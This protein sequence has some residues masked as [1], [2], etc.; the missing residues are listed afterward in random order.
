M[1]MMY[2]ESDVKIVGGK[3]KLLCKKRSYLLFSDYVAWLTI[4]KMSIPVRMRVYPV[5]YGK[6]MNLM[7]DD[8]RLE[9]KYIKTKK[10]MDEYFLVCR[11]FD[12]N[13]L[14][15]NRIARLCLEIRYGWVEIFLLIITFVLLTKG[16]I[17]EH[18]ILYSMGAIFIAGLVM[19][20]EVLKRYR[21]RNLILDDKYMEM[22]K[23]TR[24]PVKIDKKGG[25]AVYA[26]PLFGFKTVR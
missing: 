17:G 16:L 4:Q 12:C 22:V 15:T 3:I 23:A 19:G 5:G 10:A 1:S 18:L 21:K 2:Y 24:K 7:Y 26:L 13:Y 20:I 6:I 8:N 25:G 11:M 14:E 9:A